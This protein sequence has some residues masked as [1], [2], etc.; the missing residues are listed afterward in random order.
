MKW[1][2]FK[3]KKLAYESE[4]KGTP[5]V[6]L[7]GFCEDSSMWDEFRADLLEE[8]FRVIRID[9][10]GFGQ[11]EVV[12]GVSIEDMAMGVHEVLHALDA[13]PVVLIGHSMGGYVGLAFARLYPG[14]LSGLGLFHS[15]PYADDEEKK[16]NR[17]RSIDFIGRQ[18][19]ILFVKQ[20]IP[21]LF[22]PGYPRSNAFLLEKLIYRASKLD[23]T[24]IVEAQKA[25]MARAD[26]AETLRSLQVPVL[27][28]IGKEDNA[29]PADKN[30]SQVHLPQLASIHILEKAGH[31]G[32]FE[33]RKATQRF[34]RK[35]VGFCKE[36][37]SV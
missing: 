36:K 29:I 19:H 8:A 24:G 7:H 22:A 21:T 13:G 32:M 2:E 10:P 12:A 23:S 20:L 26:E 11:S 17:Q 16:A 18:G 27:F 15:H 37:Q 5:V 4:G 9:L 35:F 14:M 34:V 6:L 30:M 1:I 31:M 28:I 3:G 33:A 25:M